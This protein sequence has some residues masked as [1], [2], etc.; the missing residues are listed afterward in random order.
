MS[1]QF[2]GSARPK[3]SSLMISSNYVGSLLAPLVMA[4]LLIYF[5]WRHAFFAVGAAGL[6]FGFVY[7]HLIPHRPPAAS[8]GGPWR[9]GMKRRGG[10]ASCSPAAG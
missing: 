6:I 3:M 9:P 1:E 7:Y 5:G 2:T 8:P 10:S 4:P